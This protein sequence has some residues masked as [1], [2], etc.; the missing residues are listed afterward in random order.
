[1]T[2]VVPF[3][4]S[5]LFLSKIYFIVL[6]QSLSVQCISSFSK[7][8][9]SED[10]VC[11]IESVFSFNTFVFPV[12]VFGDFPHFDDG[13]MAEVIF[14]CKISDMTLRNFARVW[15]RGSRLF[16]AQ[17]SLSR[18]IS[19]LINCA[20]NWKRW[21]SQICSIGERWFQFANL[22]CLDCCDMIRLFQVAESFEPVLEGKSN[23]VLKVWKR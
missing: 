21:T 10:S 11:F 23:P 9:V 6:T 18:S 3:S 17:S 7:V 2:Q 19:F 15:I 5:P 4:L 1:M 8:W 20:G 22:D 12:W 16:K 13:L 14:S